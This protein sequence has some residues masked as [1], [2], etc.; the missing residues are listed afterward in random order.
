MVRPHA[1]S[2]KGQKPAAQGLQI[3]HIAPLLLL[4]RKKS[5]SLRLCPCMR[6]H[7]A[8]V[9]LPTFCGCAF[10]AGSWS[11]IH[12][13]NSWGKVTLVQA[14]ALAWAGVTPPFR[15][16][17]FAVAP[18]AL[19]A[20]QYP[21]DKQL[22][23][24]HAGS[25]LCPRMSGRYASVSLPTFCGCAFGAGSGAISISKY[26][27]IYTIPLCH[28]YILWNKAAMHLKVLY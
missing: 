10:G 16:Q 19:E 25:G 2:G 12:M 18:S 22:G 7:H 26:Q 21:Y 5:R 28:M 24:S 6:G 13:I 3:F 20:E 14:Y 15:C 1:W 27:L 23:Q 17:L 9:S 8:S 11:N 4:F